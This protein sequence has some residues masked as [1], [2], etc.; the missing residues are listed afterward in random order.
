M[1]NKK[2]TNIDVLEAMIDMI[3]GEYGPVAKQEFRQMLLPKLKL[4]SCKEL[5]DAEF[6]E[7]IE[8]SKKELQH[9][10]TWLM[11]PANGLPQLPPD[12][13]SPSLN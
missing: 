5:S 7:A 1:T 2:K 8:K 12:F 10:V 4:S 9:F 11:H 3:M 13:F 6:E